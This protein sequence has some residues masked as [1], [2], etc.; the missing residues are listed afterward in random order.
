[1]F[2]LF[3]AISVARAQQIELEEMYDELKQIQDKQE[4]PHRLRTDSKDV[5]GI[6]GIT[7]SSQKYEQKAALIDERD[8]KLME[9]VREFYSQKEKEKQKSGKTKPYYWKTDNTTNIEEYEKGLQ[10]KFEEYQ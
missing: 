2:N 3:C 1:M 7:T 4:K 6:A 10:K 5:L 9:E 8:R